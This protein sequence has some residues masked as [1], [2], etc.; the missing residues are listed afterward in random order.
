MHL[1]QVS[2]QRSQAQEKYIGRL[3]RR[4]RKQQ[5]G[6][7]LAAL[8]AENFPVSCS[9]ADQTVPTERRCF[10]YGGRHSPPSAASMCCEHQAPG[11]QAVC[12]RVS[13]SGGHPPLPCCSPHCPHRTGNSM[14]FPPPRFKDKRRPADWTVKPAVLRRGRT[15][16]GLR[17][18]S[19]LCFTEL[20]LLEA[21]EWLHCRTEAVH[22]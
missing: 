17:T 19:D 16:S 2:N 11:P 12:R 15:I 14:A 9:A 13:C 21:V 10:V 3:S 1:A 8:T 4:W 6:R 7:R 18:M 20:V 5:W 22:R